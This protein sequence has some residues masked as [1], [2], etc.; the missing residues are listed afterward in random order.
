MR[1]D[2]HRQISLPPADFIDDLALFILIDR[3]G[4][5]V[6]HEHE[7]VAPVVESPRQRNALT[8]AAR[9]ADPSLPDPHVQAAGLRFNE[10][11]NACPLERGPYPRIV[12]LIGGD[13]RSGLPKP[14]GWRAG[15]TAVYSFP[16]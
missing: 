14:P 10:L 15:R 4:R 9:D 2:H 11:R 5:L 7:H 6:E 12:H 1:N 13:I 16:R 8:L 3:R